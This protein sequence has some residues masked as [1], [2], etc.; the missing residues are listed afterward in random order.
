MAKVCA[1]KLQRVANLGHMCQPK[2]GRSGLGG[3]EWFE[4][5]G[6]CSDEEPPSEVAVHDWTKYCN[7]LAAF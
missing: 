2:M 7:I 1:A 3:Y 4:C 6:S 5:Y